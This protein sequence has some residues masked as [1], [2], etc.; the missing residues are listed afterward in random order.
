MSTDFGRLFRKR[1]A[2]LREAEG[3]TQAKLSEEI[4]AGP[5]YISHVETGRIKT[6]PWPKT[7]KVANALNVS[8]SD[9]L[10]FEGV[11]DSEEQLRSKIHRLAQT[12]NVD[13]L[14]KYYRLML[15]AREK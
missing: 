2:S 9:L 11:D 13:L 3:L 6:P 1:L 12:K 4:G 5:Q 14:R 15:V 8:M 7:T 10:F